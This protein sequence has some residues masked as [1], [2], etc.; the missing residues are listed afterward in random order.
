MIEDDIA[1]HLIT[2]IIDACR[3]ILGEDAIKTANDVP[4]LDVRSNGELVVTG[5]AYKIIGLLCK[6]FEKA[7]HG[8]LVVDVEV[9]LNL[10][11]GAEGS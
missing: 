5:D 4:G 3:R 6:E 10:K 8:K 7:L 11:R 2:G 9:R 1:M